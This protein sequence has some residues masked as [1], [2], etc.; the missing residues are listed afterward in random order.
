MIARLRERARAEGADVDARVGDGTALPCDGESFDAALC[1]FALPHFR[2]RDQGFREL[3]R[4]V[5]LGGRAVIGSWVAMER[6]PVLADI[7]RALGAALPDL[8]FGR[9]DAPLCKAEELQAAMAAAGFHDVTVQETTH[10]FEVASAGDLWRALERSTP[11][12]HAAREK[13]GEERWGDV[14]G[15]IR[16]QLRDKWG[17]GAQRVPMTANLALGHR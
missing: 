17:T 14:D 12:V 8:P 10:A 11:P 6:M 2:E 13:L 16:H 7:Y 3:W 15:R 4:V 9:A 5:K 1:M